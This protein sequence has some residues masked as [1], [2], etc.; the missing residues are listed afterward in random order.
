[1]VIKKE[2]LK[3]SQRE[4]V[5]KRPGM[6]I[7]STEMTNGDVWTIV[8]DKIKRKCV[9]FA[10]GFLKIFDE[11]I[12][13]AIDHSIVASN[14]VT[15]IKVT[16]KGDKIEV[17][18]NGLGI[19]IELQEGVYI[20]EMIFGQLL[21]GSNYN[22][23][24]DRVTAGTFGIGSK[25]TN[26][27][28]EKFRVETVS[29]GQ[30]FVIEFRNNMTTK[31]K[32]KVTDVS[33]S[34][35]TKITFTPDY[36][37]FQMKQM[38]E[39]TENLI[40][41]RVY[42][43][44]ACTPT[45]V[46]IY[47]NGKKI[48]G[49]GLLDYVKFYTGDE[50]VYYQANT[51]AKYIWEYAVISSDTGFDQVSFVNGNN[52]VSGGKHVD[53]ILSQIQQKLKGAIEKTRRIKDLKPT[54]IKDAIR[55]FVRA[56]VKNPTF[57]SQT[58]EFLTTQSKNFG[59][60]VEVP[61]TFIKKLLKSHITDKILET[62]DKKE[63][64]DIQ[65][66]MDGK[67]KIRV[68]VPN[69]EDAIWAGSSKSNS[70]S[71]ILTEGLSAMTFAIWGR[72]VVGNN[73]Y[74]VFPLRGKFLN[75]RDAS[76]SQIKNNVE[77]INLMKILGLKTGTKYTDTSEL[78]YQKVILLTDADCDGSHIK[79]LLMNFFHYLFPELL[80][81][82]F[83]QTIKTPI[84]KAS[85]GQK[86]VEFFTNGDYNK[87]KDAS[88][89]KGYKIKYYKGLGTSTKEDAK[90]IFNR[91]NELKVDYKYVSKECDNSMVLA[92]GKDK[93][94][95]TDKR[96]VWLSG[97]QEN[98]YI[99]LE[100]NQVSYTDFVNKELIH[101]S[102]ADN[103]RSIPSVVDGLKPSQRKV[104]YYLIKKG[105]KVSQKV[106]QLS[107]YI[108]AETGY[109]H[110]EVSLQQ[111]II[112]MA[113]DYIG[114]NNINLLYPDGNFGSRLSGQDAASPRYIFTRLS[115]ITEQLFLRE[116]LSVLD[117]LEDDG[118]IIE[119]VFL[120]PIIPMILVNGCSGIGT[121]YSSSVPSFSICDIKANLSRMLNGE[122]LQ[123]MVPWYKNFKG[124]VTPDLRSG[125]YTIAGIYSRTSDTVIT[126]TEIPAGSYLQPFKDNL[127]KLL[128]DQYITDVKNLSTDENT[129]IHIQVRF[130]N[131]NDL[132]KK[133]PEV[134]EKF[135]LSR[136]VNTNNMYLFD[137]EGKIKKYTSTQ[138][139]IMDYSK[140][141]ERIYDKKRIYLLDIYGKELDILKNKK[142]FIRKYIDKELDI[143]MKSDDVVFS[144]LKRAN[145]L[146]VDE[147]FG[148]LL[149]LPMSSLT[150]KKISSLD[151]QIKDVQQK[152][153]YYNVN[154]STDLWRIDLKSL[155]VS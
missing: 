127:L 15:A 116:D 145:F 42:D 131:K 51:D 1:M 45:T 31:T 81:L 126:I 103:K 16:I 89:P 37:L 57:N 82:N 140:A 35:Y 17:F 5:L 111:T 114:S 13:N 32:P 26:I 50:T 9:A 63:F 113:A 134:I 87:W 148:Y 28:S 112:N 46:S 69:L 95:S 84:L 61:D 88:S 55:V 150:Q 60:K 96:K 104:L 125:Y 99:T 58:K 133:L 132:D 20:P 119:P 54:L 115:D 64:R 102:V 93:K 18:N 70:C 122:E 136:T 146:K 67:K 83:I 92:F 101:F 152:W 118:I 117:Y 22:D 149:Q 110:G 27:Y 106:A 8:D 154:S 108:S 66:T 56:T 155:V 120:T 23:E 38:G 105:I 62:F 123:E 107:G 138:E 19:P 24:E 44:I 78:R 139:I 49:K 4:H 53:Y 137:P 65:K 11:I 129:G 98:E 25:A 91:L 10:P 47:F 6:Y 90:G 124:T 3:L 147:T 29:K 80:H 86:V 75:I 74:G 59:T 7:G 128:E 153:E 40:K 97:Y 73:C 76:A 72:S 48:K 68:V 12:Q 36:K 141:R 121:G 143:N 109:H 41:K 151:S 77:I 30:K 33:C 100:D 144:I 39:D 85:K 52:T 94:I 14:N 79:G 142:R 2:Y 130:Q 43:A 71:L 21:S 34:E 135:K